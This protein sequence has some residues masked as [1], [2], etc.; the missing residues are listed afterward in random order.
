MIL[1]KALCIGVLAFGTLAFTATIPP[2]SLFFINGKAANQTALSNLTTVKYVP[3]ISCCF[4]QF[5][6]T[7]P[8]P[9]TQKGTH[10]DNYSPHLSTLPPDPYVY[11]SAHPLVITFHTYGPPLWSYSV[12]H[13]IVD[14]ILAAEG[15]DE[16]AT[17]NARRLRYEDTESPNETA[18]LEIFFRNPMT[19]LGWTTV[20]DALQKVFKG[21][22]VHLWFDVVIK[23]PQGTRYLAIGRLFDPR[24]VPDGTARRSHSIGNV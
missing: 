8:T 16:T 1:S 11:T 7:N 17:I 24:K 4:I 21:E 13:I 20:V 12:E 14:A 9:N 23:E 3:I 5:E 6:S 15:H 22:Y 2:P 18:A 19:W 10:N